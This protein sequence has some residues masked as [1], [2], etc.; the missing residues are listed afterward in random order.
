[1]SGP[2]VSF[3]KHRFRVYIVQTACFRDPQFR[4]GQSYPTLLARFSPPVIERRPASPPCPDT[5]RPAPFEQHDIV[6]VDLRKRVE[7]PSGIRYATGDKIEGRPKWNRSGEQ[8]PR[9]PDRGCGLTR[10]RP[11]VHKGWRRVGRG[12]GTLIDADRWLHGRGRS[13]HQPARCIGCVGTHRRGR[14]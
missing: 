7:S 14:T 1:M 5:R 13:V 12:V 3:R 11:N 10:R 9:V 2:E 6:R 8:P 4:T